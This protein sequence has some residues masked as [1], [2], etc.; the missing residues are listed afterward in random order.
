MDAL[1]P[2]ETVVRYEAPLAPDEV[3]VVIAQTHDPATDTYHRRVL[4]CRLPPELSIVPDV[5]RLLALGYVRQRTKQWKWS[6]MF[7]ITCSKAA[8]IIGQNPYTSRKELFETEVGIKSRNRGSAATRHG[9]VTEPVGLKRYMETTGKLGFDFGFI[10][11]PRLPYLGG[12]PDLITTDGIVVELKCPFRRNRARINDL[13]TGHITPM[14]YVQVQLLLE[15]TGL[16][17]AHFVEYYAPGQGGPEEEIYVVGIERNPHWFATHVDQFAQFNR[18]LVEF[19]VLRRNLG[20]R[21]VVQYRKFLKALKPVP[22]EVAPERIG[23][24]F[25]AVASL[26]AAFSALV[27]LRRH[28]KRPTPVQRR[29]AAALKA[30]ERETLPPD[31]HENQTYYDD[32]FSGL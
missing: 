31:V 9:I 7:L 24:R 20:I 5:N 3:F 19:T 27:R 16:Q 18:E 22:G 11:H 8:A 13:L 28:M 25:K 23:R 12:S 6:R 4:Y 2:G 15:V 30:A 21:A 10:R 32:V 14:Y 1:L 17:M 29:A 26:L